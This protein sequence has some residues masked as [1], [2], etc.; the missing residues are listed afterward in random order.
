MLKKQ[1]RGYIL[2]NILAMMGISCYILAD[3]FFIAN[4]EGADGITALNL[5]LPIFGII[6]AIGAMIGIG[7]ATRYSISKALGST[8]AKEYF[9]NS[10]IWT[11]IFSMLFVI[12]GIF[13][14]DAVLKLMGAD[15]TILNVGHSYMQ[16]VLCFA[17]FFMVNYTFTAFA[18]NDNAPNIAMLATLISSLFNIV[19]D[20]LLMVPFGMGMVGAALATG[21]SPIVS[22]MICMTHYLSKKNTI[23]FVKKMPSLKKLIESC[24][25]GVVAFVGEIASG[26]TTMCFNFI[27]LDLVGNV[28]VA[29]YGIIANVALVG[30]SI[31]NGVSQGLQPVASNA[32]GKNDLKAQKY[33]Y[34]YSL[35]VAFVVS[36]I[37]V[38]IVCIFAEIL[39]D[40]FN[41]E[42]S[43]ELAEYALV[44]IR[45]YFIGFLAAAANIVRAGFF[46]ATGRGKESSIIAVSRGIVAIIIFA[47]A[48]S[49]FFG[50]I[51]VWMAFPVAEVFTLIFT[52]V[53]NLKKK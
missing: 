8:E 41:S 24:E 23:V 34:K 51:G 18:R 33:V 7:S 35:K 52:S 22:I 49:R 37:L 9:S 38:A 21:V 13:A 50:I 29:A 17:P 20:Y 32:Y 27:L 47:F 3:T 25:L 1:L 31:F 19:F 30:T 42:K 53:L 5:T 45:I 14:P 43:V 28:A 15:A 44:G 26:I 12:V 40:V 10:I 4:S 16:I 2:P 6:F 48:L 36:C 11:L 39:I 46:S